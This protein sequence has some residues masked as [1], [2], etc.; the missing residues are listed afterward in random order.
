MRLNIAVTASGYS[1]EC[2]YC[3]ERWSQ[4]ITSPT[5]AGDNDHSHRCDTRLLARSSHQSNTS[6][7]RIYYPNVWSS[8][9]HWSW[10]LKVGGA[11]TWV[12]SPRGA[13]SRPPSLS[14]SLV[15]RVASQRVSWRGEVTRRLLEHWR[16]GD[17]GFVTFTSVNFV[18]RG[19]TTN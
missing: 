15:S 11:K 8:P 3:I 18:I 2:V 7:A 10:D 4:L 19:N 16:D 5:W 9:S 13:A 12:V 6:F 17:A 1:R 14:P